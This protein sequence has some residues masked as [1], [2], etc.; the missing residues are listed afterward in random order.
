MSDRPRRVN[1]PA[2][3][4]STS[5]DC[6]KLRRRRIAAG[7]TVREAAARAGCSFG[8]ISMLENGDRSAGVRTLAALARAYDCQIIDLMPDEPN[9]AAA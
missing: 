9:G 3:N 2:E 7:L 8:H 5:Q 6:R 4:P 1:R